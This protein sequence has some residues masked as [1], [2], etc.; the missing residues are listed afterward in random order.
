[1]WRYSADS[2]RWNA[3]EAAQPP[4]NRQTTAS[5]AGPWRRRRSGAGGRADNINTA[6]YLERE[7]L[8]GQSDVLL[9]VCER[10]ARFTALGVDRDQPADFEGCGV[11]YQHQPIV[12]RLAAFWYE[13][14][15]LRAGSH[16]GGQIDQRRGEIARQVALT[17][18][19]QRRRRRLVV[20]RDGGP[21]DLFVLRNVGVHHG[22]V[23]DEQLLLRSCVLPLHLARLLDGQV[24]ALGDLLPQH[25][26]FIAVR[27]VGGEILHSV[28]F[29]L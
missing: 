3:R 11:D 26:A 24:P 14:Q 28:V 13:L 23:G 25:A 1:S 8:I 6:R 20:G 17:G 10:K 16:P 18:Q 19:K 15:G 5:T 29:L 21:D 22:A 27:E 4:A 9:Q 2:P 7:V 12:V